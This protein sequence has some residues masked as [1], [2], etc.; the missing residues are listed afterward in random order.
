MANPDDVERI[1]ERAISSFGRIDTWF[2]NAGV[3]VYGKL[4]DVPLED[5]RRVFETNFWGVVHGS[6]TAVRLDAHRA[7]AC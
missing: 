5:Q 2:N 4:L 7:A 6:R 3:S 1:G